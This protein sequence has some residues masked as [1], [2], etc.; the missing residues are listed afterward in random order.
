MYLCIKIAIGTMTRIYLIPIILVLTVLSG[1]HHADRRLTAV[2]AAI[3]LSPLAAIDS[4]AAI[5]RAALG[6]ADR[7]YYDFLSV[8]AADKAYVVHTTDTVIL[9]VIDYAA[10]HRGQGYYPEALYYG[11]RVYSDMGDYPTAL[12][13]LHKALDELPDDDANRKLRGNIISQTG[14]LLIN[15]RLYDQAVTY[16]DKVI[17]M[18]RQDNDTANLVLDLQL[19]GHLYI[20]SGQYDI[21]QKTITESLHLGRNLKP[22]HAAKSRMYLADIS[23]LKGNID[24]ALYYIRGTKD[25]IDPLDYNSVLISNTRIFLKA[26]VL[27]SAYL[28]AHEIINRHDPAHKEIAYNKLLSP[29]LSNFINIDTANVYIRDYANLLE[30]AYNAN[31]NQLAVTQ[32]A[33]YNYKQHDEA[34]DKAEKRERETR[35]WLAVV[36][37]I[38]L[39]SIII[40][41]LLKYRNQKNL[42]RLHVALETIDGIRNDFESKITTT[43]NLVSDADAL[44]E[45]LRE[46]I[47]KITADT[48]E[49]FDLPQSLL[50]SDSY[51]FLQEQIR[52]QKPIPEDS[53]FWSRL[54]KIIID[55]YPLFK[56]R[57]ELLSG[58]KLSTSDFRTALLIK[59]NI[60][61]TNM[62]YLF[63]RSRS[64]IN[65]RRTSLAKKL[66]GETMDTKSADSLI[67]LL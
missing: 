3:D 58:G 61:P 62:S 17:E 10:G 42:I 53:R 1:C 27:D 55:C 20:N 47:I 21:A 64:S 30:R 35:Y 22:S 4:L 23:Y 5:D 12:T 50:Q 28:Y 2:D 15:L 57:L 40:I 52:L 31:Q 16:L 24:S 67:R 43:S 48:D 34:R 59:C 18:E 9:R 56:T 26:G 37:A 45:I 63:S 38:L 65:S 11:G 14:R 54:E 66:F 36:A 19:L 41:L 6:E 39:V 32:Q 8:K 25:I 13:Y 51:K 46:K 49:N 29:E 60:S 33:M 44:R 7:N